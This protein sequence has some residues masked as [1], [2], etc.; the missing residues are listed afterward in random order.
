MHLS[1]NSFAL[2]EISSRD[3]KAVITEQFEEKVLDGEV[4]E[5][6]LMLAQKDLM[7]SKSRLKAELSWF[8]NLNPKKANE[9]ADLVRSENYK[10]LKEALPTLDGLSR[11]NVSAYLCAEKQGTKKFLHHLFEAQSQFDTATILNDVNG[12][13]SLA[14]FPSVDQSLIEES[15]EGLTSSHAEAALTYISSAKH[16]GNVF[17]VIVE[18]Y[19]DEEEI[20]PFIDAVAE[21]Y[22]SWVISKLRD[23]EDEINDLIE[24][25]K[26]GGPTEESIE[27]ITAQL[28]EWEKYSQP[29]QLI[30]QAKSLDEKRAKELYL[31]MRDVFLWLANDNDDYELS[32]KFAQSLRVI[33]KALPSVSA[34]IEEDIQSLGDLVE[35]A[36]K[37]KDLSGLIEK[38][39]E[40]LENEEDFC[41]SFMKGNFCSNGSG[42]AGELYEEFITAVK[43][44]KGKEHEDSP[45]LIM[46]KIAIKLNN[47]NEKPKIAA[48]ILIALENASPPKSVQDILALDTATIKKNSR[49]ETQLKFL[50]PIIQIVSIIPISGP[51]VSKILIWAAQKCDP[52]KTLIGFILIILSLIIWANQDSGRSYSSRSYSSKSYNS[53]SNYGSNSYSNTTTNSKVSE[54]IPPVGTNQM[55]SQSQIRYCKYQGERLEYIQNQFPT[56]EYE[57]A[58]H[59]LANARLLTDDIIAKYDNLIADYNS[60][61]GEYRYREYD[62][63]AVKREL[64]RKRSELQREAQQIM[65]TWQANFTFK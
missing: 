49:E 7:A 29:L 52:M 31:N 60:R 14:G 22:D 61:C 59:K 62:L 26:L 55:H 5:H 12:N 35:E 1:Q 2:L 9:I 11:A 54:T 47:E 42:L 37:D 8:P 48:K 40:V 50:K 6:D 36:K 65:R 51:I 27:K 43:N 3:N 41:N 39:V 53:S 17:T 21:K 46:R 44:T 45:W 57:T 19:I 33:F 63:N 24:K 28:E 58:T 30:Y 15:V 13:P 16:P 18:K 4:D 64:P 25:M 23:Y 56:S 38:L 34:Q 10:A 32:L 20:K